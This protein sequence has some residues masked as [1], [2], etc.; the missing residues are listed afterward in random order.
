M[1]GMNDENGLGKRENE[2]NEGR[3]RMG[4]NGKKEEW[5]DE[6]M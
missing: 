2:A 1:G 6:L 5:M 3:E 4:E